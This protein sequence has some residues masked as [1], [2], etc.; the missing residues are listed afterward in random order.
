MYYLLNKAFALRGWQK[1]PFALHERGTEHTAFLTLDEFRALSFCNGKIDLD[2]PLM[3]G[4][5]KQILAQAIERGLVVPCEYGDELDKEQEYRQYPSRYI[6]SAHWSITGRCNYNCKHCYISAPDAK[7]GELT[8]EQC[9]WII[10]RLAE[11]GIFS[12]SLTGGECLVRSDFLELLDAALEKGIGVSTIYSNGRLV[13]EKLLDALLGRGIRPEFNMSFDGVG[14]HDWLRGVPGAQEDVL[15]AFRLCKEKGFATGAEMCL[16]KGNLKTL[17][18]SVNVLAGAGCKKLK[19]NPISDT[20][21]W[22]RYSDDYSLGADELYEAYLE[23]I[24]QYY[25]D[26]QPLDIMLGGFF[27]ARRGSPEYSIAAERFDG[28]K[29]SEN[30]CVCEHARMTM[31]IAADGKLLPCMPLASVDY[32]QR[33]FPNILDGLVKGLT[34]SSY[35]RVI[36]TRL[37][38][39]LAHNAE[40]AECEHA[41]VCAGGCRAAGW[42]RSGDFLSPDRYTCAIFKGGYLERIHTA[43]KGAIERAYRH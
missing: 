32:A 16:H 39:Y 26:G 20:E 43:A 13:D 10:D 18:E 17:R 11:C 38:E 41:R 12:L 23:Y 14:W 27:S 31:Y 22:E 5:Y 24:P 19:V 9:L 28:G 21:L 37:G 7:F 40:C 29:S 25:A 3:L 34:D 30:R 15:R 35:M 33:N 8:R 1:L 4:R 6:A 36:D 42:L 2:G